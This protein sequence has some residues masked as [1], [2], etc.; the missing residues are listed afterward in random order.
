M[1]SMIGKSIPRTEDF[2]LLTGRG[3]FS[4]DVNIR[5]QAYAAM[6]RSPHAHARINGVDAVAALGAPGVIAV[7]TGA[8]ATA[9]GLTGISHNPKHSSPPDIASTRP[10]WGSSATIEPL[11]LGIWRNPKVLAE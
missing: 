7:L 4:D 3:R 2:R 8:D 6:V 10:V 11:I 9:D 1:D 5:G